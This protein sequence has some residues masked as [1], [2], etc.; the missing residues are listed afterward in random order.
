[1]PPDDVAALE[2]GDGAHEHPAFA[3]DEVVALDQQ[4]TEVSRQIGLLIIG[5]AQGAGAQDA[6]ARLGPVTGGLQSRAERAKERGE[7]FDIELGVEIGKRLGDDQPIFQCV[8]ASGRRLRPVAERP[9][10]AVGSSADV[11]R[12]K[13][14]PSSAGRRHAAHGGDVVDR[15]GDRRGRQRALGDQLTF[16]IDVGE[17]LLQQ[18]GA[19]SDAVRDAPP[20]RLGDEQR[21]AA[22]RPHALVLFASD[23]I[24]EPAIADAPVR[25]RKTLLHLIGLVGGERR[26]HAS[27]MRTAAAVRVHEL[28]RNSGQRRIAARPRLEPFRTRGFSGDSRRSSS[29]QSN[30]IVR[31][32]EIEPPL[33]PRRRPDSIICPPS[34]S[35]A[36]EPAN[37]SAAEFREPAANAAPMVE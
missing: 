15:A 17:H 19:L 1:M 35:D 16:A 18:I 26:Q 14:Q 25:R 29:S 7:P 22:D 36:S 5:Q 34:R 30:P 21:H 6:D 23:T 24:R 9:P 32:W 28:I 13:A 27:P 20:L 37:L 12:I 2:A 33:R 3:H 31:C 10:G 8:A 11:D 4:E